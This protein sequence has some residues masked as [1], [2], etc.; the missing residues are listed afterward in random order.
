MLD[1]FFSSNKN[2]IIKNVSR[3]NKA[4]SAERPSM[5]YQKKLLITSFSDLV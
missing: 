2:F 1:N 5:A 4:I 3:F